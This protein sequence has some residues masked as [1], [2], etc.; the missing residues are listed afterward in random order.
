MLGIAPEAACVNERVRLIPDE[1]L[2]HFSDGLI[3]QRSA[4]GSEAG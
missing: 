2:I 4:T 3:E 1:R